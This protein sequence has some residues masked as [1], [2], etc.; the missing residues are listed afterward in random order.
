MFWYF[1]MSSKLKMAFIGVFRALDNLKIQVKDMSLRP[2][3]IIP[4]CE[5]DTPERKLS[6]SCVIF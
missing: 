3:S 6:S 2:F 5:R 4:M 1:S